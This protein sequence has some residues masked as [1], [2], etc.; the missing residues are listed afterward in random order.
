MKGKILQL[1]LQEEISTD[2]SAAQRSQTSGHLV[3]D[4][5]K[6]KYVLEGKFTKASNTAKLNSNKNT[7]KTKVKQVG[8]QTKTAVN[9]VRNSV[10]RLEVDSTKKLDYANIF[11]ENNNHNGGTSYGGTSCVFTGKRKTNQKTVE[12]VEDPGFVDNPD[13]PPL[14]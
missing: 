1:A 11:Q 14:E 5:P 2:K 4:M 3:I 13:V 6:L 7:D 9:E 12:L 8:E 10:Q